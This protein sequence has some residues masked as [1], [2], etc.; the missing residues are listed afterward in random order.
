[1]GEGINAWVHITAATIWVGPQFFLA[2]AAVP[3]VRTIED[4]RVRAQVMRVITRRFGYLAWGAMAVLV[5]SGVGNLFEITREK[6]PLGDLNSF[7]Y[8]PILS[9]KI[10]LVIATI[11]L[12]AL[13]SFVL[14]PRIAALQ[15][16][17]ATEAEVASAR[18]S[19]MIVSGVNLL[20]A[21]GILF[22]AALLNTTFALK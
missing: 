5:V 21:L 15:E 3:A 14:G 7:N 12:T 13:H 2:I 8:G 6:I 10:V 16:S 20:L 18:R 19:S 17:A 9:A 11:A 1:M 4:A 22:C